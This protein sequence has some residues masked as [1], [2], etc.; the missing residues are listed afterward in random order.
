VTSEPWTLE[1][2]WRVFVGLTQWTRPSSVV[3]LAVLTVSAVYNEVYRL[4]PYP[5]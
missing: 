1:A 4:H 2:G 3:Q 5:W